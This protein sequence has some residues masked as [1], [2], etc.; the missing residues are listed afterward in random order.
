MALL[1]LPLEGAFG[2]WADDLP[3]LDDLPA[4]NPTNVEGQEP[5]FTDARLK[6]HWPSHSKAKE[7]LEGQFRRINNHRKKTGASEPDPV[8]EAG[9]ETLKQVCKQDIAFW[10]NSDFHAACGEFRNLKL[11]HTDYL[12]LAKLSEILVC[13]IGALIAKKDFQ[14]ALELCVGVVKRGLLQKTKAGGFWQRFFQL[15]VDGK[16]LLFKTL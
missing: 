9:R 7:Y 11:F 1:L 14:P 13:S 10:Q 8:I 12:N 3:P 2:D 16:V 6:W 5:K 4:S 15:S